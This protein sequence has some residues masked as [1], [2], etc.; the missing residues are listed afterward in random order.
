MNA[1]IWFANAC[2]ILA[3]VPVPNNED[4]VFFEND[5]PLP[6]TVTRIELVLPDLDRP[7]V[8]DVRHTIAPGHRLTILG[9]ILR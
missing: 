9:P 3:R 7:L 5:G 8:N 1:E 4:D 2:A 6:V